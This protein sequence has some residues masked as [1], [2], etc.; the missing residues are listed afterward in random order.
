MADTIWILL[1]D[2][3]C[4][5]FTISF[6]L[7]LHS[8]CS[9]AISVPFLKKG[10]HPF[11]LWQD[12]LSVWKLFHHRQNKLIER[13]EKII[14]GFNVQMCIDFWGNNIYLTWLFKWHA[15]SYYEWFGNMAMLTSSRH[16]ICFIWTTPGKHSGIIDLANVDSWF[17]TKYHF[18]P[19]NHM[20]WLFQFSLL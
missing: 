17:I 20:S 18:H 14:Q 19:I 5:D 15:T 8:D 2:E 1:L 13:N 16:L 10:F 7:Y 11:Y 3:H 4:L 9:Q 12:A 6:R